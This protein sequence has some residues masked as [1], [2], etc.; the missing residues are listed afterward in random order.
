MFAQKPIAVMD[1]VEMLDQE[2]IA[3]AKVAETSAQEL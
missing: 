1:A 3:V 2:V